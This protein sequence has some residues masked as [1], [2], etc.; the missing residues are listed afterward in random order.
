MLRG[1][2]T[3][4]WAL[5]GEPMGTTRGPTLDAAAAALASL[6]RRDPGLVPAALA[7]V[8]P[9]LALLTPP[10]RE[11]ATAP[12]SHA[13]RT[14]RRA[15]ASDVGK[16]QVRRSTAELNQRAGAPSCAGRSR[17]PPRVSW[18]SRG[19]LPVARDA[20]TGTSQPAG[21]APRVLSSAYP[22]RGMVP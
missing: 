16:E 6:L 13:E 20:A 22:K 1:A 17:P 14:L 12:T 3:C 4:G 9:L 15:E 7:V 18:S 5:R 21:S 10:S 8:A 2:S 11:A 19:A